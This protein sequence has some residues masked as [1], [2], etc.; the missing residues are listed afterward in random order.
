MVVAL[1]V[2]VGGHLTELFDRWDQTLRTG[3]DSDYAVVLVAV[4]AAAVFIV[5]KSS[6]ALR[7]LIHVVIDNVPCS[8]RPAVIYAIALKTFA[9]DLSPPP[10]LAPI[11]I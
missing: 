1:A 4:S 6:R 8:V 3:Q 10:T 9:F 7:R 2:I 11:R 5:G